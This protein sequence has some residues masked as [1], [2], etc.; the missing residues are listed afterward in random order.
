[1][2]MKLVVGFMCLFA[3]A[4]FTIAQEGTLSLSAA[5]DKPEYRVGE[6]IELTV[7]LTNNSSNKVD[8]R[9]TPRAVAVVSGGDILFNPKGPSP[10][11]QIVDIGPG[12]SWS[13]EVAFLSESNTMPAVGD[14]QVTITYTNTIEK[15]KGKSERGRL[16][17][18]KSQ[19]ELWTGEV[20]TTA[21]LKITN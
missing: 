8:V 10:R 20:K 1:M 14:Y 3:L 7:T 9:W 17:Q 4:N 6:P 21:A 15:S 19:K 13:R 2:K 5:F 18:G 11:I 16:Q 12:A